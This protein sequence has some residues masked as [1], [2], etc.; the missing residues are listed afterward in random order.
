MVPLLANIFAGTQGVALVE[1]RG[2][3]G[4]RRNSVP[5]LSTNNRQLAQRQRSDYDLP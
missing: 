1:V 3:G 5:Q 4:R 2:P